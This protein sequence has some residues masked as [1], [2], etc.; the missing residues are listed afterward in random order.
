MAGLH[1]AKIIWMLYQ[2]LISRQR[3]TSIE[4]DLYTIGGTLRGAVIA[5]RT[6]F[7][8][9]TPHLVNPVAPMKTQYGTYC[10]L[11]IEFPLTCNF[12][13]KVQCYNYNAVTG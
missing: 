12:F 1:N 9:V 10:Q 4:I 5:G 11:P 7:K 6:I 8:K 2:A 3:S 13:L